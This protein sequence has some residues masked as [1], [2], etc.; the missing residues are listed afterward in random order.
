MRLTFDLNWRLAL[1]WFI[2]GILIWAALS[3]LANL[4][5]FLGAILSYQLP[6]PGWSVWWVVVVL[7]W[8][9]L[10]CGLLLI[11]GHLVRPALAWSA[12]LFSVFVLA[13]GQAWWR[14]LDIS[15]GCLD[16]GLFGGS[17]DGA[18]VR[19]ISSPMFAFS[20]AVVLLGAVAALWCL[21]DR[22]SVGKSD[23]G[24]QVEA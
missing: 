7:P 19:A 3:K 20:R 23:L 1:R 17:A 22:N 15:C 9:E 14:G 18:L 13:T 12:L 16:W 21:T 11:R 5:S 24:V 8:L 10:L 4:Q 6:L 2:G